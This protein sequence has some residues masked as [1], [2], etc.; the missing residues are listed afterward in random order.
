MHSRTAARVVIKATTHARSPRTRV[1]PGHRRW[2]R[3]ALEPFDSAIA[4][5]H[6]ERPVGPCVADACDGFPVAPVQPSPHGVDMFGE[7]VLEGP[8]G[9]VPIMKP[10][11]PSR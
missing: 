3:E 11:G 7:D 10:H 4:A 1:A 2:R 6:N 9:A 8:D 5:A